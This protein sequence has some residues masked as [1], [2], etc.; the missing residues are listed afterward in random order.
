MEEIEDYLSGQYWE[1]DCLTN[2]TKKYREIKADNDD[3]VALSM[4]SHL[5]PAIIYMNQKQMENQVCM[6][7]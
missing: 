1:H 6:Y 5:L 2:D 7:V 4:L 3:H